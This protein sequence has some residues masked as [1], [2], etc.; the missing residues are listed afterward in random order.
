MKYNLK[1]KESLDML[2]DKYNIIIVG[3]GYF[4]C[5]CPYE[6]IEQFLNDVNNLKIKVLSGF[7]WWC[8]VPNDGSHK[9]CGYGGPRTKD[10]Y[11]SE[12]NMSDFHEFKSIKKM[13]QFLI[14]DYI[15]SEEYKPCYNPSFFLSVDKEWE[16]K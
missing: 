16:N 15:L 12:I 5:I 13:K 2:I 3:S 4:E 6:F 10:G 7:N 1:T 11:Y 14:K 9:S 8:F